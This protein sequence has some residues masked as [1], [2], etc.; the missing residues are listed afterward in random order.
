MGTDIIQK[1]NELL[2]KEEAINKAIAKNFLSF[3]DDD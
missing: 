2:V 1:V 3:N